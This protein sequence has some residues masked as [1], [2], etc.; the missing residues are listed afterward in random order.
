[1]KGHHGRRRTYILVALGLL[2]VLVGLLAGTAWAKTP[3]SIVRAKAAVPFT[4]TSFTGAKAVLLA[5]EAANLAV[6]STPG[7]AVVLSHGSRIA[8]DV[9]LTFD[10]GGLDSTQYVPIVQWLIDHQIHATIFVAG[11][12]G[13]QTSGGQAALALV[14]AHPDLFVIGNHSWDHP[15]FTEISVSKMQSQLNQTEAAISPLAGQST[16]PFF[17]P[18]YGSYNSTVLSAVGSAGWHYL[19][20]WDLS[21]GDS[22]PVS[23]GGPTAAAIV[24]KVKANVQSG[25]IVLMHLGGSN[26]YAALPGVVAA[27]QAK[28]LKPVT[29]TE[30]LADDPTV[31]RYQQTD[32]HLVYAGTWYTFKATGSSGGSYARANTT[33]SLVTIK[34]NGRYLAWI[35][36]VGTTLGKAWVSLDN[37]TPVSINLAAS[38]TKR[39]VSVWNTGMFATAGAHVVKIS[40]DTSSATGKYISID[41]VDVVGTLQ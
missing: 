31:T 17:R 34:F 38:S 27:V 21:T 2:V 12:P 35:A 40:R 15:R 24:S 39:Q 22:S 32:S 29:L 19:V 3:D 26:T 4:G 13:S 41:A 10:V 25:S 36:T 23:D 14:K 1:M 16:K 30:L 11:V 7:P 5:A 8:N 6:A 28:G 33:G 18:P 9:A 20:T 37:G